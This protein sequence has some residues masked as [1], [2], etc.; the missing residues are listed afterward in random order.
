MDRVL[1]ATELEIPKILGPRL[2]QHTSNIN[3]ECAGKSKQL[4]SL[5]HRLFGAMI[6]LY[7]IGLPASAGRVQ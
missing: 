4:Y 7:L 3:M 5:C 1:F 6:Y 2:P